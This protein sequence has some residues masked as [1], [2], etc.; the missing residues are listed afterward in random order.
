MQ[1]NKIVD[2]IFNDVCEKQNVL[3]VGD[4]GQL[5]SYLTDLLRKDAVLER[6]RFGIIDGVDLPE[7]DI[8][9]PGCLDRWLV[10]NDDER[11]C[12]VKFHWVINCAAATDTTKIQT[13]FASQ[14]ES[15]KSNVLGPQ[16]IARAC[17]A[18]DAKLVHISTDYVFSEHSKRKDGAIVEFPTNMYGLHKLLGEKMIKCEFA[19]NPRDFMILR[20]SWLYGNSK[21]SFPVK[22]LA[23]CMKVASESEANN[24][25]FVNVVNDCFGRPTSVQ[26][27]A[28]FIMSAMVNCAFGEIDAQAADIPISRSEFAK[29]ILEVWKSMS[30]DIC[31][32][33]DLS[34]RPQSL[35]KVSVAECQSRPDELVHHPRSMPYDDLCQA[36]TTRPSIS[37]RLLTQI[38]NDTACE[39]TAFGMF[40][41]WMKRFGGFEMIQKWLKEI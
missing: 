1:L 22:F 24:S 31:C 34:E 9:C 3:V 12:P 32:D 5:G 17:V 39:S 33:K 38:V 26:Y 40:D 2:R 16:N 21:K 11:T 8:C 6:S 36:S 13:D 23:N 14:L 4:K 37:P 18:N 25:C 29:H 28:R 20:T 15:Y 41:E 27:L 19:S 35:D 30:D 7:V 10:R